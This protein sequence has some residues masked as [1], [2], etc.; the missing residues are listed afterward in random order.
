MQPC[1]DNDRT[2]LEDLCKV[3]LGVS[4]PAAL[5]TLRVNYVPGANRRGSKLLAQ[6]MSNALGV[7][8]FRGISG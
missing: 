2:L 3:P 8:F 1:K 5:P 4:E 7:R 6:R